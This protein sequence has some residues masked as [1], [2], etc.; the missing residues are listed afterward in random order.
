VPQLEPDLWLGTRFEPLGDDA[1]RLTLVDPGI[2][3]DLER[4]RL[5]RGGDLVG[6]LTVGVFGRLGKHDF[7]GPIAAAQFNLSGLRARKEFAQYLAE[8]ARSNEPRW[9][10]LCEELCARV[11]EHRRRGQP[12]VSLADV[13]RPARDREFSV[14][15]FRFPRD[16]QTIPFGDGGTFKSYFALD[17]AG[18][19]T[20]QGERVMYVDFEMSKDEHRLRL[21]ALFGEE[22][23]P[24]VYYDRADR[25]LCYDVDRL[26]K[27]IRDEKIT[28]AIFDSIG[29]ATD[30]AP[31]T[32]EA[33][34]GYFRAARQL[35]IGG[36]HIAHVTKQQEGM[37]DPSKPFGSV[38]YHNSAR[39]TWLVKADE[40]STRIAL[41]QKKT[42][43]TK[44]YAPLCYDVQFTEDR[45]A[46]R[47]VDIETS[48]TL[49]T[50]VPNWQRIKAL[51][52]RG[53][54]TIA[55]I[56]STLDIKADSAEKAL[57]RGTATFTRIDT[58]SDRVPRWGLLEPG[59]CE[60]DKVGKVVRFAASDKQSDTIDDGGTHAS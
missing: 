24:R 6:E 41:Y 9:L 5:A 56:A 15:G 14:N 46:F 21:S 18:R 2:Q 26:R 12:L 25:P 51:L 17:V 36:L 34:L 42:N 49:A 13:P 28:F 7:D 33:A 45:V 40:G 31:E 53:P 60:P 30:G 23:M 16:H 38:F 32:A 57:K 39:S 29:F 50:S 48:N 22:S 11:H 55:E 44:L 4:V 43:T 37:P 19:L 59:F 35:G 10:D 52:G 20:L 1:Y 58:Y 47:R 54:K 3:L 27:R 8:R